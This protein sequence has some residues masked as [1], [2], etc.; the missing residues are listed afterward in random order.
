[1]HDTSRYLW[2]TP[3]VGVADCSTFDSTCESGTIEA[4]PS[5][6][7]KVVGISGARQNA[8][9]AVCVNGRLHAF[10][11]Q[12]RVSRV[13]RAGIEPGKL[14]EEAV[15]TVLRLAS[16]SQSD[17]SLIASAED[18]FGTIQGV[19]SLRLQ[20]HYAHAA[21]AFFTAPYDE[22]AV[23]VC[24]RHNA[25]PASVWR[26]RQAQLA[27]V[28]WDTEGASLAQLYSDCARIFEFDVPGEHRLEALARLASGSQADRFAPYL[29]YVD[30]A[31]RVA[32]G[33]KEFIESWLAESGRES[34]THRALVASSFQK[35]VG[36]ILLMLVADIRRATAAS[37]LCLAGGL[38]YNTYFN[39]IIHE[40]DIFDGVFVPPNPGNA[41]LAAGCALAAAADH[42][43]RPRRNEPSPF[44]GPGFSF[45]E[46]KASLDNCK[47]SYDCLSEG[48]LLETTVDALGRGHMVGWFQGRMEWGHRALGNR[49][50]LASPLSPYVLDNLNLFL[51]HRE[52]HRA[53]GLSVLEEQRD[54]FFVGP[55]RSRYMEY[56]YRLVDRQTLRHAVPPG[57]TGLRVQ[58]V[59]ETPRLFRSLH[60]AFSA[61]TGIG[62]LVNT[63]FNGFNEPI[64]CS[65][66][67]AIRVFFGTGLDLLVMGP[68]VIRK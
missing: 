46:I 54:R 51:K 2:P 16:A 18:C 50:I 49:S 22:A 30:G 53:Y 21:T 13:R 3:L 57:V 33:W 38:F 68:F 7:T 48:A 19:P 36:E 66:R 24:D 63:S 45:E 58:T 59:G 6:S 9:A 44:L 20:H 62:V 61:A 31:V 65:P 43:A 5:P 12:E 67:D 11:E 26:A 27:A 10:C 17:I 55:P 23:L 28:D 29:S 42:I 8:A 35:R 4:I 41:G 39:T 25:P 34:G 1:M 32:A 60:H 47:L 56:E 40:S 64:V 52:R 15:D 14:P 37:N